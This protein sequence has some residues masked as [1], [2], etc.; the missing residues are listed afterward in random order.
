[1]SSAQVE[2]LRRSLDE[3]GTSEDLRSGYGLKNV[4]ERLTLFFGSGYGLSFESEKSKGTTVSVRIPRVKE[5]DGHADS[6]PG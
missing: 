5:I 2:A 4:H 1:M 6:S 3:P